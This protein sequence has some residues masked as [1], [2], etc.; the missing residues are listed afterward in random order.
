MAIKFLNTVAVDTDVLYVDT[1]NDRAGIGT[2]S[3]QALLHIT[4]TVNADDTKFYLTEN[5]SLLGGYF[6]YNGGLNINY[7]GGLDTTERPVISYPR[8]GDTLNLITNGSI[9]LH[10]D[11]LRN[12]G[13][14]TTSPSQ[15][16]TVQGNIYTT[17]SIRI[18][19]TGNQLEFGNAN[20]ALQRT[21]NLLE[22]GGY[23]GIV[24]KSSNAVLDS[25]AERMRIT[26]DG[27]VGIGT[28]SPSGLL[29]I[30]KDNA[31]ATF[32]IQGGL[33]TQTTAGAVNGEINFG[34]NDPS[35]TGGIGAS[36]K[37]I[38]QISN[39]AH[40]GLAFYTGL[41]SRTPYLQQMLYFTAQGGLSFGT[42]NSDY[43]TS[44]QILK[45]N[46]DAPP[47]WVDASTV[48]GGPY[49]PLTAGSGSPLT[50][51]LYI[52]KNSPVLTITDTVAS[53][54]KLEI[55]QSGSTAN[56]ISRGGT[57]SKGQFNFRITDGT[58][59]TNALFINQQANVGVGT[60]SPGARLDV[61]GDMY[62]NSNYPSNVAANDL[63]IGKTT[64][65]DH[66]LTIV[67]GA[68][69]TASIFFADN[70]NN[71]A[72]R[73]KYQHSNNSMRF[74]TNRSEAMRIDSS[75]NV[76]IGTTSP[77][78]QLQVGNGAGTQRILLYGANSL[79]KSSEIIFGDSSSG[80]IT[81]RYGAGIRFDSNNNVLSFRSFFDGIDIADNSLIDLY[82]NTSSESTPIRINFDASFSGNVGIGTTSPNYPLDV[83]GI[84]RSENSSEVGTLYLGNTAQSEIPGGAIIGQR[85]PNYSSTGNLLF[86]VPTWGANTDYGLTTQMSIEV[87]TSDTK[88]ATISMIPFGGD[89]LITAALLSNQENTDVDTGAE[90]VAQVSHATYT[91]AFFDFVVKKGTNVRSGTVYAC[92][93]GDTTPLVEFTE[94]STQDLGD[95]S[96]VTLS[97]DISGTNMR[98]LATVTSDDWSVKSLIRAI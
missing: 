20:V 48:I 65:G 75:G 81:Y 86:Q 11:S 58:T 57:S 98:L 4:G 37:N 32:E 2:T 3:P 52:T 73:I 30:K 66:G 27:N 61:A 25:Q 43:G 94:T 62:I 82:R 8:A 95:T 24:F 5:N 56:F 53:D 54:L 67:T 9:A 29:H 87:S 42:S 39:G 63:T 93:N 7:I 64:T 26:S 34:V 18:E 1:T 17:G 60:N 71:D 88:E 79:A 85:S 12:V 21:S 36:I 76:G 80:P 46:A 90:V 97:V 38:S 33:N 47:T 68:S 28:T 41:Q 51:D 50:G 59:V 15:K 16:L 72:G 83:N 10:I 91:A 40:N 45:S 84:I 55:K 78:A 77:E 19:T 44:G 6:K 35:T 14:G 13:I 89:V 70:G 23:D 69:N 22:L 49:L 74:E 92:H 31:L 96:D